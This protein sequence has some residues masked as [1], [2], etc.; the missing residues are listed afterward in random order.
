MSNNLFPIYLQIHK[1]KGEPAL[2][3]RRLTANPEAI[4]AIIMAAKENKPI[5]V[6]P[7][8][9]YPMQALAK[10]QQNGV[11]KFNSDKN[12]YEFVI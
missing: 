1:K 12:V 9:R 5:L 7:V 2:E 10:L 6:Y 11:L 3:L 8:F 4:K